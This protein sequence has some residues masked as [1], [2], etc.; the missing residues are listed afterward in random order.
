MPR[1]TSSINH[2]A[3]Q[4]SRFILVLRRHRVLLDEDLAELYGV[5]T[6]VLVQAVK[7]NFSRFPR[8]FMF[9]LTAAQWTDLKSQSVISN[10]R[11]G[12]GFTADLKE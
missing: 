12:I 9:Q 8:D 4:I 7:R 11:R 1:R 5:E 2:P 6:R 3:V 10:E